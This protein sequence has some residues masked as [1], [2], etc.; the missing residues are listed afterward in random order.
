MDDTPPS[1]SGPRWRATLVAKSRLDGKVER[2][3]RIDNEEFCQLR[4]GSVI[5]DVN[6]FN[7]KLL[8]KEN[9]YGYARLHGGVAGKTPNNRPELK[10]TTTV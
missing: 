10:S 2:I 1:T 9:Y 4:E 8:E 7:E 6:L 3:H 5:D